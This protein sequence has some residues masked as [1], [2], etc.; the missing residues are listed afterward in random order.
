MYIFRESLVHDLNQFQVEY[1]ILP[2]QRMVGIQD[3]ILIRDI[4]DYNRK[5]LTF[6]IIH[7]ELHTNLRFE[8]FGQSVHGKLDDH[9]RI[10]RTISL[11]KWNFNGLFLPYF[12]ALN[13]V[14]KAFYYRAT[15]YSKFQW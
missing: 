5:L 6:C 4:R 7:I 13:T 1:K 8:V 3:N 14:V 11:G 2:G 9:G 10:L 15:S 12:H